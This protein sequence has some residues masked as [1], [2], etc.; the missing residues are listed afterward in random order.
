MARQCSCGGI[1]REHGLTGDRVA[2]TCS[3]CGRYEIHGGDPENEPVGRMPVDDGGNGLLFQ[4]GCM[5]NQPCQR[6]N[7]RQNATLSPQA[8]AVSPKGNRDC[9]SGQPGLEGFVVPGHVDCGTSVDQRGQNPATRASQSRERGRSLERGGA[10][11][12]LGECRLEF[13]KSG[14]RVA[15]AR[16]RRAGV[17]SVSGPG[18]SGKGCALLKHSPKSRGVQGASEANRSGA[19]G[20][21]VGACAGAARGSRC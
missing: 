11:S 3:A 17:E 19:S 6:R 9:A 4:T 18:S 20:F 10:D 2:W 5:Y 21:P 7:R 12:S 13:R 16:L 15:M 8:L 14:Q 1:I